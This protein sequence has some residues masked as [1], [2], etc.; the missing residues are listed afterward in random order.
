MIS[1]SIDD[2]LTKGESETVEFKEVWRDE[3]LKV[4]CGF[5]NSKGGNL[6][7]GINDNAEII[8]IKNSSKLLEVLPNK[9][10]NLLG[11]LPNIEI[12]AEF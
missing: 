12:M 4:L 5:S 8:G 3:F 2:I 7:I 6:Y 1:Y 9:I 10:N 11:I